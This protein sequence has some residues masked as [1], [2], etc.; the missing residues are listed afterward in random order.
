MSDYGTITE[1]GSLRFERVLPG[2]IERVWTYLTQSKERGL[3]LAPGDME[4]RVGGRLEM[5]WHNSDLSAVHEPTPKQYEKYE[6]H[7]MQGRVTQCDPPRLLAFTWPDSSG[8]DSEV[9][10]ELSQR[11]RDVLLVLTHR[12]PGAR[13]RGFASGWHIHLD[14]LDDR[15]HGRPARPFWSAHARMEKDYEMR[16][17]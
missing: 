14:I 3:W 12:H 9:V 5:T 15:L 13:A 7:S 17:P 6:G 1:G 2:P 8:E 10:F 16:I 4:L 11:G